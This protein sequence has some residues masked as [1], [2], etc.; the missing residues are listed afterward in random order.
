MMAVFGEKLLKLKVMKMKTNIQEVVFRWSCALSF[1]QRNLTYHL[2]VKNTN[3]N[4]EVKMYNTRILTIRTMPSLSKRHTHICMCPVIIKHT[5][6]ERQL[7]KI[8]PTRSIRTPL[9]CDAVTVSVSHLSSQNR[10]ATRSYRSM[11]ERGNYPYWTYRS[12]PSPTALGIAVVLK[13]S[14]F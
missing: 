10:T 1:F 3:N 11:C 12:F 8:S 14:T 13:L 6:V 9:Q 7:K 4:N 2:R 5:Y